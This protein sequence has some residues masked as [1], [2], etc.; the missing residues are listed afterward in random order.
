MS[1]KY[2]REE[3]EVERLYK[4]NR[5]LK[6][7]NRRLHK[8]V[9]SLNK[10][11]KSMV[12]EEVIEEEQVPEVAKKYCYQCNGLYL[13]VIIANRRFRQCQECGKRGKVTILNG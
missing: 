13:E 9:K 2:E 1:K 12:E 10:G 5:E 3:R 6:A 8:I 4:L 11:Y 7:E